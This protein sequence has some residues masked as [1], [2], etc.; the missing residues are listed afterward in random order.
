M[1]RRNFESVYPKIYAGTYPRAKRIPEEHGNKF[2]LPEGKAW[3]AYENTTEDDKTLYASGTLAGKKADSLRRR[4]AFDRNLAKAVRRKK[5]TAT[6]RYRG[7]YKVGILL[8]EPLENQ[9]NRQNKLLL[10]LLFGEQGGIP[11]HWFAP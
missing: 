2:R 4:A 3:A 8:H 7:I 11:M 6:L 10:L 5:V 9:Y 1:F